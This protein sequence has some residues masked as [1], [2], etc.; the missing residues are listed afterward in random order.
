M[1]CTASKKNKKKECA[2]P[3]ALTV[4]GVLEEKMDQIREEEEGWE[5]VYVTC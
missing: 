5:G 1:G 3:E 4:P 2:P